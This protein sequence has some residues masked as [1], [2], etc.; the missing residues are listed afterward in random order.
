[1]SWQ[2]LPLSA[3][4]DTQVGLH[5]R[6][7][8]LG[9]TR[10]AL[11]HPENHWWHTTLYVTPRGLTTSMMPHVEG[12]VEIEL[13]FVDHLLVFRTDTA[14][15]T[16]RLQ[17]G[18]TAEFYAEYQRVL[19]S[20]RRN[21]KLWPM[22][23]EM[24]DPVRFTDDQRR[25]PYD[26]GAVESFFHGLREADDMLKQFRS[27]FLGKCSPSHFWWGSFDH[28]STRFSGRRAPL[29]PGGVPNLSD[30]VTR[31]AYSHECY[32]AGW[33]PGTPGGLVQEPAFYA[34]AYPEPAGCDTAPVRP[35]GARYEPAMREWLLPHRAVAAMPDARAG[36]MEFLRNT[37]DTVARL[38]EWSPELVRS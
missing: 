23:V 15:E 33:W 4:Q 14:V 20:M 24:A 38:G 35:D 16:M 34:Y 22:P 3:W 7:Q 5:L 10:L 36:V 11:A 37:Y 18:T 1:M 28:A 30:Y 8:I 12:P 32:S 17:A 6:T 13:D 9:K 19:N 2:P 21:V 31:E 25:L 29:H 26:S 27:E